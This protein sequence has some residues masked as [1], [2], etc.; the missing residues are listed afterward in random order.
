MPYTP[1]YFASLATAIARKIHAIA[2]APFKVIALDCDDTLWRGICGEDGPQG[3]VLDPP[4]RFL[5][6]FMAARRAGHVCSRCAARTTKKTW[7]RAFDAHPEMPLQYGDFAVARVNWES[8]GAN[9]AR[10]A[11]ELE[12]GLDI[13][14]PGGRQSQGVPRD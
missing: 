9:M 1:L 3:V 10:L 13:V 5:Q 12:L 8:K 4:R 14:H 6:E 7:R 11:E 2:Q